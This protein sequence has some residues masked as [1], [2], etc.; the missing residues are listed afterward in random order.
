MS[1][2][3]WSN[4]RQ[5]EGTSHSQIYAKYRPV[6]PSSILDHI[7]AWSGEQGGGR[8]GERERKSLALDV[9]CGSGQFTKLLV[10]QFSRVLATDVSQ[11]Q[12]D[13]ARRE[14]T[15]NHVEVRLG[16]GEQL[17][18]DDNTVDMVSICQA[19][20]WL[21]VEM[22]YREVARVL[23]QG[24][25]LAV[26]GYHMTRAAPSYQ[27]SDKLNA[28][29][30]S[31]YKATDPY[32]SDRRHHVDSGYTSLPLAKFRREMREDTRHYVDTPVVFADWIGYI[33]TW[34]GLQNM[35]SQEGEEE[36]ETLINKFILECQEILGVRENL[37]AADILLRTQ[38]WVIMYQ[39]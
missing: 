25:V 33:R 35:S 11:A 37:M 20:H 3:L 17:E 15:D 34:S 24:G 10:P 14:L 2:T 39:K 1:R 19:L 23:V 32:W 8:L 27:Q 6:A 4:T 13:Q 26:V 5:F 7:L 30:M 29:F 18:V 38:Y 28:A 16:S 31:L 21:D 9:G 12:V 36:V 22:F